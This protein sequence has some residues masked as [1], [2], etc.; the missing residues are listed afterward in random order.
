MYDGIQAAKAGTLD[1]SA[2]YQQFAYLILPEVTVHG[3]HGDIIGQGAFKIDKSGNITWPG[4]TPDLGEVPT[5]HIIQIYLN[6]IVG[7]VAVSH[8]WIT[9]DPVDI[10][11]KSL[12]T[13]T[14]LKQMEMRMFAGDDFIRYT[15]TTHD[16]TD[17][18]LHGWNGNDWSVCKYQVQARPYSENSGCRSWRLA[19]FG[20]LCWRGFS[21]T[22]AFFLEVTSS[23]W[24]S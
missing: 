12:F 14:S 1:L 18:L 2:A 13:A 15:A 22:A 3:A 16:V 19:G 7:G 24:T 10:P 9:W 6:E 23:G 20:D 4:G 17:D 8:A 11:F 5:N 21:A